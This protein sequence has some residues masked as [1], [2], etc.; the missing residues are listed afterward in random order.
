MLRFNGLSYLFIARKPNYVLTDYL[1]FS[2]L[3]F[4]VLSSKKVSQKEVLII[5]PFNRV[6]LPFT[7]LAYLLPVYLTFYRFILPF[8][9]LSYLRSLP[10]TG[11]SYVSAKKSY[12][13]QNR[14]PNQVAQYATCN[15]ETNLKRNFQNYLNNLGQ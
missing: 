2:M 6:S 4:T 1:T 3:R 7:G 11:L 9:G 13:C 15:T 8:T 14:F 10:F 5:L 12:L